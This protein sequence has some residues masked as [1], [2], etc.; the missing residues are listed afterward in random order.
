MRRDN[1][2]KTRSRS[3]ALMSTATLLLSGI[4][5]SATSSAAGATGS[6]A[7]IVIASMSPIS[8]SY[9]NTPDNLAA[10]KAAIRYVNTHGGV[11]GR[12]LKL[13]WCNEENSP[14]QEA[15]CT[16]GFARSNAIAAVNNIP[17]FNE[18]V[19]VSTLANAEMADIGPEVSLAASYKTP[20][21]FPKGGRFDFM[22]SANSVHAV[23][24][25]HLTK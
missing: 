20:S 15:V 24:D 8:A 23:K 22:D 18:P 25:E 17:V 19:S 11:G 9:Y 5:S 10:T 12:D 13:D 4:A 2:R 1:V 3:L 6:K 7:P 14:N 16:A 21:L